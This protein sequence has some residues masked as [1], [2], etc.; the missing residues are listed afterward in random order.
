MPIYLPVSNLQMTYYLEWIDIIILTRKKE[1]MTASQISRE[2]KVLLMLSLLYL[3]MRM[4]IMF[5]MNPIRDTTEII[6]PTSQNSTIE[7]NSDI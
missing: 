7:F 3:N 4:Q 6:T 2:A 5:P 1:S